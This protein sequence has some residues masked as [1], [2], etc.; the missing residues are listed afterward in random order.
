MKS[1][2]YNG[3]FRSDEAVLAS[4]K[5]AY[6]AAITLI[7]Y[8]G[9]IQRWQEGND[10]L[11]YMITPIEYQFLNKRRNIPGGS[12]FYWYQTLSLLDKIRG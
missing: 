9:E 7:D 3:A 6:L 10:I 12:L 11:K 1:Y 8:E 4:A 2:I 5:A